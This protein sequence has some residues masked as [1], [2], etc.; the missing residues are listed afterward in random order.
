MEEI[1]QEFAAKYS[2]NMDK[3][4]HQGDEPRTIMNPIIF[5]FIGD[6]SAE[7][8]KEVYANINSEFTNGDKVLFFNVFSEKGIHENNVFNFNIPYDKSELKNLRK[9]I[10]D[11]FFSDEELLGELNKEIVKVKNRMLEYG[12]TF[13]SFERVNLAVV[14]RVD[15]PLNILVPEIT[16]L[17]KAKLLEHFLIVTADLY[18][19]LAEKNDEEDQFY[20]GAVT[21]SFFKEME[22]F[23]NVNFRYEK[24]IEV[25]DKN[26]RL[27][28]KWDKPIFELIYVLSD[29]NR[30]GIINSRG[31]KE[32]Y[33]I[34]S[35][36]NLIKNRKVNSESYYDVKNILYNDVSF[37]RSIADEN[38][39]L[40]LASAGLAVV[41][42]P[43]DA[44]AMTVFSCIY[45]DII[46]SMKKNMNIDIEKIINK[47][48]L[49]D[50]KLIS[51]IQNLMP[52]NIDDMM[53]I[54]AVNTDI[55][56][57]MLHG[58]TFIEAEEWFYGELCSKFY[59]DNFS[60][61]SEENFE[62][63]KFD[64]L[65]EKNL[66][67][68]SADSRMGFY[69]AYICTEESGDVIQLLNEKIRSNNKFIENEKNELEEIYNE[70]IKQTA[71]MS[72][73]FNRNK[74]ILDIKKQIFNSI[75][76]RKFGILQLELKQRFLKAYL[77]ELKKMNN[78]YGEKIEKLKKID[79][80][81]DKYTL[82]LIKQQENY[83][84]QNIKEYYFQIVKNRLE[85][86]KDT[87]GENFYFDNNFIGNILEKIE[88]GNGALVEKI[89]NICNT[90]ILTGEEFSMTFEDELNERA[91]MSAVNYNKLYTKDEIFK[92]LCNIL[93]DKCVPKVF[94]NDYNIKKY[95]EK[96][97]F[98]DYSSDFIKYAYNFDREVGNYAIGYIHERRATGIEKLSLFGGFKVK[99]LMYYK[100]AMKYY[101][102]CKSEGYKLSGEGEIVE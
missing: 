91:N 13:S 40:T 28:V 15:D 77:I 85:K 6:K 80:E 81:V 23:Q 41:K 22:A 74:I 17:V 27:P 56:K 82:S 46:E 83:I 33:N 89:E 35:Y 8:S 69:C 87:Y 72:I 86:L 21:I 5:V 26:R 93:E 67:T 58:M 92:N 94:I 9:N 24:N 30:K 88:S 98:G 61:V 44:V 50:E 73:L 75:Y 3:A 53:A 76:R 25:F 79:D 20:N 68:I 99:D 60:K 52:E 55:S 7:A 90:Y 39:E 2:S 10:Y 11:K 32:N 38:G 70:K 66:S 54:M 45:K 34:I 71:F 65:V 100:T 42:K 12:N 36:I 14:T 64:K 49:D 18:S 96:Y 63:I 43:N 16:L 97:F 31:L 37:K 62:K 102:A 51:W 59:E 101:E 19:L 48:E 78:I 84:G 1:F 95:E 4:I 47:L 57:E 29:T